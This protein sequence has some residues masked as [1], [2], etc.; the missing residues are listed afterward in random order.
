[1]RKDK[2]LF[3]DIDG[4]LLPFGSYDDLDTR[5][6]LANPMEHIDAL[7]ERTPPSTLAALRKLG[8]DHTFVLSSTWRYLVPDKVIEAYMDKIGLWEFF[9]KERP[10]ANF[11]TQFASK[12]RDIAEWTL[13]HNKE[14]VCEWLTIDDHDMTYDD[15][16]KGR[17]IITDPK[18]GYLG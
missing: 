14:P 13:R 6:I 17:Q 16:F 2:I 15:Q 4:V 8:Q 12:E 9:H 11:A 5:G 18:V 1:M 7:A 3:L 10:I